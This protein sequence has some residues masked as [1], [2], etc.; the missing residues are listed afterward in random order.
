M[1]WHD[2]KKEWPDEYREVIVL[3]RKKQPDHHYTHENV[4]PGRTVTRP[5]FYDGVYVKSEIYALEQKDADY[6]MYLEDF[7][8]KVKETDEATV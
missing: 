1:K 3:I 5:F 2:A 8:P 4:F 6:W 7:L